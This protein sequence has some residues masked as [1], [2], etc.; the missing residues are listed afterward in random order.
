MMKSMAKLA[1][2]AFILA[3][4][5]ACASPAELRARDE[6]ACAS[7]GFQPGSPDFGR[8]PSARESCAEL[9]RG[10]A[11]RSRLRRRLRPLVRASAAAMRD[12]KELET[13]IDRLHH[14]LRSVDDEA[15]RCELEHL[16]TE[17]RRDL[18][19]VRRTMR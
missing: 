16:V 19:N 11:T 5:C 8:L 6:A 17:V 14:L 2:P 7:Y 12:L 18:E 15:A 1:P 3:C 13:R 4:L 10:T 9:W